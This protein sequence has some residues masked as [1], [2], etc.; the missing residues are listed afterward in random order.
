M[1]PGKAHFFPQIFANCKFFTSQILSA[2][3]PQPEQR[4][5]CVCMVFLTVQVSPWRTTATTLWGWG[6]LCAGLGSRLKS[7]EWSCIQVMLHLRYQPPPSSS[8]YPPPPNNMRPCCF[9]FFVFCFFYT[10]KLVSHGSKT[11]LLNFVSVCSRWWLPS[12]MQGNTCA[13]L[14]T[15]L[16]FLSRFC[17]MKMG[18]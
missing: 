5:V 14:L 13:P 2:T 11:G 17:S 9:C 15:F 18:A 10:Q 4:W 16:S 12:S 8:L 6:T 7:W 1:L 3:I